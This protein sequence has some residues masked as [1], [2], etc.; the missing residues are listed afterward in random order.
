MNSF[1]FMHLK[2]KVAFLNNPNVEYAHAHA[3]TDLHPYT[4]SL[5]SSHIM[6]NTMMRSV[7]LLT[8]IP[9]RSKSKGDCSPTGGRKKSFCVEAET[10]DVVLTFKDGVQ[11]SL[12][13]LGFFYH[14][15]S[16]LGEDELPWS[17]FKTVPV[18]FDNRHAVL[19][20]QIAR[21]SQI[22]LR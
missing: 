19:K 10:R 15:G 22:V 8:E 16:H 4:F 5:G 7:K 12:F 11:D 6:W 2:C 13:D 3:H 20:K 9:A 17:R 21:I 18:V 1:N 14:I